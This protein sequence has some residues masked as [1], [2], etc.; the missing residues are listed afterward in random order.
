L[1]YHTQSVERLPDNNPEDSVEI[2]RKLAGA[3]DLLLLFGRGIDAFSGSRR[4]ALLSLIIPFALLP[5]DLVSCVF[6][7]PKGMEAGFSPHQVL[8]T[9]LLQ[10]VVSTVISLALVVVLAWMLNKLDRFWL[11]FEAGNWVGLA[12][13]IVTLPL[14]I[15][16]LAGWIPREEMD[17]ISVIIQCYL[18]IVTA[19]IFFRSFQINW[20]LA[21]FMAITTLFADQTAWHLLYRLQGIADPW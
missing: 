2:K 6:Y 11:S 16:A 20:Q 13:F 8:M 9:I 17:R 3:F 12:A 18:Y 19:C 1:Y 4:A 14:A 10:G 5:I 15:A 21:G 7:P